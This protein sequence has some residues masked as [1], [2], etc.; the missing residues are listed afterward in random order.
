MKA[1][2]PLIESV[3][4]KGHY[5]SISHL[6]TEA[7]SL[8]SFISGLG[9][10]KH[11][12]SIYIRLPDETIRYLTSLPN[13]QSLKIPIKDFRDLARICDP[14]S[15]PSYRPQLSSLQ[16]LHLLCD[17]QIP[18]DCSTALKFMNPTGLRE[19]K[20]SS[21]CGNL[22]PRDLESLFVALRDHCDP[23][24][25]EAVHFLVYDLSNN[26]DIDWNDRY[27][28]YLL[29]EESADLPPSIIPFRVFEP[30]LSDYSSL[31]FIVLPRH[32]LDANDKEIETIAASLPMLHRFDLAPDPCRHILQSRMTLDSILSFVTHC[33][34]LFQLSLYIDAT[35]PLW[36]PPEAFHH[37]VHPTLK[38]LSLG[39][40][41][42]A[43]DDWEKTHDLLYYLLPNLDNFSWEA[44]EIDSDEDCSL[45]DTDEDYS[46]L[47][48]SDEAE[49]DY[50]F[51]DSEEDDFGEDDDI[52]EEEDDDDDNSGSD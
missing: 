3:V 19:L 42:V 43:R 4:L 39:N 40:S 44:D 45:Y 49:D 47:G 38:M 18:G 30:F 9:H 24:S 11:F 26:I 41:T 33:R 8:G 28:R 1:Q 10:L 12:E 29:L 25:F 23:P 36:P 6:K 15:N 35:L 50:G 34:H 32:L 48:D 27:H 2:A 17:S 13:L 22:S 5:S 16:M 21:F 7:T 46:E 20:I 51:E 52:E 14:K 31:K 37:L